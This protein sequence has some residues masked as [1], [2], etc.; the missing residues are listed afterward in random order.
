[1]LISKGYR[2]CDDADS[3][4]LIHHHH[5]PKLEPISSSGAPVEIHFDVVNERFAALLPAQEFFTAS[6]AGAKEASAPSAARLLDHAIIHGSL[7]D[8]QYLR[9]TIK[10]R[11]VNDI[12]RLW[13]RL[14]AGGATV[15]DLRAMQDERARCHFGACL[16]LSGID[17]S[18]LDALEIP[19]RN[20]LARVLA[21]QAISERSIEAKLY[22]FWD[23]FQKQRSAALKKL[24]APRSYRKLLGYLRSAPT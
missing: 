18:K 16:L 19:A 14:V 15:A 10:L 1:V 23:L 6:G 17:P 21:R 3:N 4:P 13:D 9:R 24:I 12:C 2:P 7:Q 11:D 20:Y 8:G 5:L 22:G